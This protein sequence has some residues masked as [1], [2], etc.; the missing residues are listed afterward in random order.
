[1]ISYKTIEIKTGKLCY[2]SINFDEDLELNHLTLSELTEINSYK[3]EKRKIIY[4]KIRE[5]ARQ[6]GIQEI[7]YDKKGKPIS[8][9][10][11]ISITH[12][13]NWI[14]L[15]FSDS[16]IGLDIESVNSRIL[17]IKDRF[18][19]TEELE[20]ICGNDLRKMALCWSAKEA[21]FKKHG[22]K[23]TFFK[24]NQKILFLGEEMIKVKSKTDGN[25]IEDELIIK[26]LDSDYHL[27]YTL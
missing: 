25:T 17:K 27:V 5:I 26:T 24:E 3:N 13:G 9:N 22:G 1:M 6:E 11:K 14:G 12:S 20:N 15:M 16:P 7:G 18:L 19:S 2:S 10:K 21:V 4:S 8:S 23:T